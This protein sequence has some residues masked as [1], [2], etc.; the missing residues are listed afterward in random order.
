MKGT[1]DHTM[2]VISQWK[3]AGETVV[4]TNGVFDILHA[5]HVMYL[6]EAKA[7]GTRLVV[8]L[9]SDSSVRELGKGP[10]RPINPENDRQAVLEG[11]RAVDLVVVFSEE[12]P[13][14]L[15][16]AIQPDVLVKGGDYDPQCTDPSEPQFIVGSIEVINRGGAVHSIPLLPGRSTTNIIKKSRT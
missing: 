4:F 3:K 11:L 12:T 13:A 16:Q 15:I 5:G 10:E 7:F 9:N 2:Q 1:L 8:G 6:T 14:K